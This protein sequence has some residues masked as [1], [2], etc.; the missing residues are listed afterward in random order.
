MIVNPLLKEFPV[1]MTTEFI[2]YAAKFAQTVCPY[3]GIGWALGHT[4]RKGLQNAENYQ[5]N[6]K[7]CQRNACVG[8]SWWSSPSLEKGSSCARKCPHPVLSQEKG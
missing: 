1:E 2:N 5:L 8:R 3:K 4:A 7:D 6:K